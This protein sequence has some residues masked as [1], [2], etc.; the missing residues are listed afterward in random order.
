MLI[1]FMSVCQAWFVAGLV[2][3]DLPTVFNV[4]RFVIICYHRCGDDLWDDVWCGNR[5]GW[6]FRV[7]NECEID[8]VL[9]YP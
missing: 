3:V 4:Q 1:I 2:R 5:L 6:S 7:S 9:L 8:L